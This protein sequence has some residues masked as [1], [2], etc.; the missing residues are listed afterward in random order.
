MKHS[1]FCTALLLPF[2]IA[3]CGYEVEVGY[4]VF[5]GESNGSV[6]LYRQDMNGMTPEGSPYLWYSDT[7][8]GAIEGD[9]RYP[10]IS[11]D[12]LQI[13]YVVRSETPHPIDQAYGLDAIKIDHEGGLHLD[14]LYGNNDPNKPGRCQRINYPEIVYQNS[15]DD[16]APNMV[17]V[18]VCADD[19]ANRFTMVHQLNPVLITQTMAAGLLGLP[20]TEYAKHPSYGSGGGYVLSAHAGS[21]VFSKFAHGQLGTDL[22]STTKVHIDSAQAELGGWC[23]EATGFCP[24]ASPT[25]IKDG[26]AVSIS[27]DG[28]YAMY[29]AEA[30][31]DD[32]T[33]GEE[34]FLIDLPQSDIETAY[35]P[36]GPFNPPFVST[37]N[38]M[39]HINTDADEYGT[40]AVN[41]TY[42]YTIHTKSGGELW[43]AEN[44]T[45]P[46][47]QIPLPSGITAKEA[48][49]FYKER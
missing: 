31:D 8:G 39:P 29:N 30:L 7:Q 47:I 33:R 34:I 43:V 12:G 28:A 18:S 16:I 2:F 48:H 23:K 5:V 45:S 22:Q 6:N 44:L 4:I 15:T 41:G 13:V 26:F 42:Q 36:T 11:E 40:F 37:I 35:T 1:K 27:P 49:W 17:I 24:I 10:Q 46:R 3:G 14:F 20:P 9:A 21:M 38:E 25:A 19:W 32:P